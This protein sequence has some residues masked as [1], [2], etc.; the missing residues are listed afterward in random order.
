MCVHLKSFIHLLLHLTERNLV[1]FFY[2]LNFKVKNKTPKAK[3]VIPQE[4][5]LKVLRNPT[6]FLTITLFIEINQIIYF[7][8]KLY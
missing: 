1:F 8:E 2:C 3:L 4:Q 7:A 6:L 5:K